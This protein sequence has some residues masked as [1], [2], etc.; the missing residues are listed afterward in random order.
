VVTHTYDC[1]AAPDDIRAAVRE[2]ELWR[3]GMEQTL[4]RLAEVCTP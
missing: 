3:P 2:G 1:T 4:D